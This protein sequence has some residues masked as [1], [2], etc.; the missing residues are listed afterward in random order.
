MEME[1]QNHQA[2]E[3]GCPIWE[4]FHAEIHKKASCDYQSESIPY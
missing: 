2:Q 4:E 3:E 1:K